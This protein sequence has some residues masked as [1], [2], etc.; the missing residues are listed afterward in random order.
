MP[1]M[2]QEAARRPQK[3]KHSIA[4]RAFYLLIL[5]SLSIENPSLLQLPFSKKI[6]FFASKI[7]VWR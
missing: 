5:T 2:K 6:L 1:A 3:F 4:G 7:K